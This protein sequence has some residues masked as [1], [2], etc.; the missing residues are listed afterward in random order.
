MKKYLLLLILAINFSQIASTTVDDFS[1]TINDIINSFFLQH[2]SNLN[3]IRAESY[4]AGEISTRVL[5]E[6]RG[7]FTARIDSL[8][9]LNLM[10]T[11]VRPKFM[12]IIIVE[13]SHQLNNFFNILDTKFFRRNGYF[14]ITFLKGE[15][16]EDQKVFESFWKKKFYNVNILMKSSNSLSVLTFFPFSETHSDELKIEIINQLDMKTRRLE[17][18]LYFPKKFKNLHQ[19]KIVQAS[20]GSTTV[21]GSDGRFRAAEIE[22]VEE[23]GLMLNFSHVN[24]IMKDYELF[25]N[26]STIPNFH[27]QKIHIAAMSMQLDRSRVFSESFPFRSEPLVLIIPPGASFSPIEKLLKTFS[28]K[29]WAAIVIV[30]IVQL[31]QFQFIPKPI[32]PLNMINAFLGGSISTK[33][34]PTEGLSRLS[35]TSFLLYALIIRTAY[36]AVLVDYHRFEVK[37]KEVS[38]INEIMEKGFKFYAYKSLYFRLQNYEFYNRCEIFLSNIYDLII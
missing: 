19:S 1:D 25:K 27:D 15:T 3:I 20:V 32:K 12:V 29:V 23:I 28:L 10:G 14:V 11:D 13:R 24:Q 30:F 21:K 8:E 34:L 17:R 37:H 26:G 2:Y 35:F 7:R 31:L 16:G 38:T 4:D 33:C 18:D 36:V 9:N 5:A 6:A 22:I